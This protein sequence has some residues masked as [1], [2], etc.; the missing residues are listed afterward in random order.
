MCR[1]EVPSEDAKCDARGREDR[2]PFPV[3]PFD[4]LKEDSRP[5]GVAAQTA[6]G[7]VAF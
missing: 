6:S 4:H 5:R 7:Y 3:A 1:S 2:A